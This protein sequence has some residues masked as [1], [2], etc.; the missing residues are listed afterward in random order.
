MV[1]S[2][3]ALG[4]LVFENVGTPKTETPKKL[5][6]LIQRIMTGY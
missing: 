1:R 5:E 6:N 4:T 3:R 2:N